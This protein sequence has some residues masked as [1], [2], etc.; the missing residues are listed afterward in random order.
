MR[1]R[2]TSS[3]SA[4]TSS[5]DRKQR[6]SRSRPGKRSRANAYAAVALVNS[7]P[8][9]THVA[10]IAELRKK[11]SNGSAVSAAEKFPNW[12]RAGSS[13]GGERNDSHSPHKAVAG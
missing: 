7:W 4:G 10:R 9:T 6:N 1:K 13:A 11:R 5:T 2:G 8:T 3:T 12:G